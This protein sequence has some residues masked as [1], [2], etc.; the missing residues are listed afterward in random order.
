MYT[1]SD[2][3][4]FLRTADTSNL[5]AAARQLQI[6]P[7]AASAALKRLEHSLQVRL[8]ERSTRALR[9]TAEGEL[10]RD[11]CS[12]ALD[13]LSDGE[14]QVRQGRRALAG[15]VHLAAPTDLTRA[16][17][18]PWL[19]EFQTLYPEVELVVHVSDTLQ[20]LLRDTLQLAL[21]YGSLPDS[22]LQARLLHPGGRVLAAAP[23]YLEQHGH[24]QTPEQLVDHAC[25]TFYTQGQVNKRW[26]FYRA[27]KPVTVTVKGRRSCDDS[28][29]A[30]AW[31]LQGKGLIY[32]CG[33]ELQDDLQAGRLQ[34]LL[35]DYGMEA[36][37]LHAVYVGSK[38]LPLRVRV[39]LDF[40]IEKFAALELAPASA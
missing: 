32:K 1:L 10:F 19:D 23:A 24:P 28:S 22:R 30:R 21:R 36:I 6:T 26:T 5:S 11:Y 33:L 35:P 34:A 4:L 39:L 31:A 25:L 38:Y 17:L 7:A 8:F 18:M 16:L 27:G 13:I 2:L 14:A 12:R 40:F 3:Q 37:P 20:D 29:L 15:T 9:L